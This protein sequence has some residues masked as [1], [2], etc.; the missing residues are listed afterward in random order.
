MKISIIGF[1]GNGADLSI[2]LKELLAKS[3]YECALYSAS[4]FVDQKEIEKTN[5]PLDEWTKD[6]FSEKNAIV[7]IGAMGIAVRAIAP[8]IKDKLNDVPVVVIDEKGRFVIPVLSGHVGGANEL[9]NL[10]ASLLNA[11]A[12]ITTATD[13]NSKFAVDIFAKKNNLFITNKDGIA[14]VSS[15]V[16][17]GIN[18]RIAVDNKTMGE[19]ADNKNCGNEFLNYKDIENYSAGNIYK[20]VEFLE[21]KEDE[22]YDVLITSDLNKRNADLILRTKE[23]VLGI[24]CKKG[25]SF[26]EIDEFVKDIL[27]ENGIDI[28]EVCA[29][30]SID[31]KKDEEGIKRFCEEYNI[32]F[33]TYTADELK[34]VKGDFETSDFVLEN[35]GVD[36]VCERA[37][38]KGSEE[39]A[40]QIAGKRTACECRSGDEMA[41]LIVKKQ[42]RDGKTLAV[43][44]IKR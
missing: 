2:K 17:E 13:I 6:K 34:E 7:F 29:V 16:L 24:G 3:G 38:V 9:A 36:N 18:I 43:S 20:G 15:K 19:S 37:A 41:E 44:K 22:Y 26:E 31:V 8:S 40:G 23:Y 42:S 39:M 35:V 4:S 33:L 27:S 14:K 30:A 1:T 11:E 10:M 28:N 32:P 5:K 12:V 25:K 21:Y